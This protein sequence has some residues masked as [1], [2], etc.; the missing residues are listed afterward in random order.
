M[1][2]VIAR[3]EAGLYEWRL[4]SRATFSKA[5]QMRVEK[6]LLVAKNLTVK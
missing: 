3:W 6:Q 5:V 4:N 1:V 2:L